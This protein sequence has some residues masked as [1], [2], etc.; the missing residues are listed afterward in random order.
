MGRVHGLMHSLYRSISFCNQGRRFSMKLHSRARPIRPLIPS[1]LFPFVKPL[2]YPST[3]QYS[4]SSPRPMVTVTQTSA[5]NIQSAKKETN[6]EPLPDKATKT[7]PNNSAVVVTDSAVKQ[8]QYLASIKRSDRPE[9]VFLRVFV[10][11][12][13]CSGF[14]YKFEIDFDDGGGIDPQQDI[15]ITASTQNGDK[16]VRVVIDTASLEMIQGS[17]LDYIR[18]MIKSSFVVLNNPQSEQACGC[19]SSFAVKAFKSNPAID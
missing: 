10:D 15:V 17:T 13:G 9:T 7:V 6:A 8:I 5:L 19:G 1:C 3:S 11:S 18:E 4:T 16:A 14:Q 12:G 2:T